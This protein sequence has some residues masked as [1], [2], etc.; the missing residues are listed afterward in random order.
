MFGVRPPGAG[1]LGGAD[2]G[3]GRF[4]R[5]GKLIKISRYLAEKESKCR[6]KLEARENK[7][8]Y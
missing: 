1:V 4:G 6:G 5:S 2:G 3:K 8:I 7:A